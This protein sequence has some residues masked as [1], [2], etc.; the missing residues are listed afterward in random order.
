MLYWGKIT[1]VTAGLASGRLWVVLV[2][3]V[4]GHQFDRG[5]ADWSLRRSQ[6]RKGALE[7]LPADFVRTLFQTMGFLAKS[8]GRVTPEEIR[9]ARVIMHRLGLGPAEIQECVTCF[10]QGKEATF[11]LHEAL[12]RLQRETVKHPESRLLFLRLLLEVCLSKKTLHRRERAAIWV[13]CTDL[14]IGRVELAQL[15]AIARAQ[16]HFRQAATGNADAGRLKSA[17]AVLGLQES[18]TNV[19]IKQAYRRLMNRNHPDKLP[20]RGQDPGLAEAASQRTR[21]IREAYDM[22]KARRSIR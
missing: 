14:H 10:E 18:S 19:E 17:Y 12:G 3:L 20:S 7:K 9:A 1:G 4:L 5:F 22:L 15:E 6:P 13:V 21:E 11:P 16:K 8:D 2:G